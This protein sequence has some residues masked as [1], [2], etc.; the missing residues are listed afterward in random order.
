MTQEEINVDLFDEVQRLKKANSALK[1]E[2][3]KSAAELLTTRLSDF[4]EDHP[5]TTPKQ[6]LK[7]IERYNEKQRRMAIRMRECVDRF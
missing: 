1:S 5:K 3:I 7:E 6:S 4:E 2:L